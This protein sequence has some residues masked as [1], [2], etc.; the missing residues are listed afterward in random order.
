MLNMQ[1]SAH[2]IFEMKPKSMGSLPLKVPQSCFFVL[3]VKTSVFTD[4]EEAAVPVLQ[5]KKGHF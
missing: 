4:G 5:S 3:F 1:H 2:G